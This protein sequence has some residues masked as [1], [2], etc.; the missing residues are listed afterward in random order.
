MIFRIL[1]KK[2][3]LRKSGEALEHTAHG[4]GGV[5]IPGGVQELCRCGTE[6]HSLWA[7]I[8]EVFSNLNDF[9]IL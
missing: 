1:G 4:G 9:M 6:G 3:L 8:S 2:N 5:N 7:I